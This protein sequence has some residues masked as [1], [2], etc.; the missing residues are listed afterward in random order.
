[1][2]LAPQAALDKF[3]AWLA[4]LYADRLLAL[5]LYGS[6]ANG[7]ANH[8]PH[9]SD[10]N[11]LAVLDRL[12]A[13]TLDCGAPAVRWWTEQRYPAPIILSRDEQ[14]DS[15]DIFPIEYLDIQAHH[16]LLRGADLFSALPRF[17]ELHRRQLL[18]ELRAKLLRL[19]AAYMLHGH[20][21]KPL[22]A[23]LLDSISTFLTL[24][25]HALAAPG[26][27][28]IVAKD[29]VLAAAAA[30]FGFAPGPF[31][32]ILQARRQKSRL[33]NGKLDRLRPLF[34]HYLAAISQVERSLEPLAATN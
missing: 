12:D 22:E 7:G 32:A 27:P 19:R 18:H 14:Q 17:P 34:A 3:S 33:E 1:M 10:I 29:D 9:R 11:L 15:A 23:M 26:E 16:R 13:A 24:F 8:V 4:D 25:R 31:Q 2:P 5:V 30:K 21:A 28:L 20:Q 6:F